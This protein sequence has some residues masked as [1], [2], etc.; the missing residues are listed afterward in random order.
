MTTIDKQFNSPFLGDVPRKNWQK[1]VFKAPLQCW[2]MGLKFLLPP[3]F[4]C[5]TTQGRKS[6]LPRHTMVEFSE[7]DGKYYFASGWQEKPDWVQ[8]LMAYSQITLH[9]VRGEPVWGTAERTMDDATLRSVFEAMQVSPVWKPWL[10]SLNIE[11]TVDDFVANKDRLY[12]FEVVPDDSDIVLPTLSQDRRWMIWLVM[13]VVALMS[14]FRFRRK[15]KK[16]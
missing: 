16:E 1:V 11:P 15:S 6:G 4:A 5:I 8:N 7:I 14:R 12:L 10:A 2:R 13:G 9:P 3:N